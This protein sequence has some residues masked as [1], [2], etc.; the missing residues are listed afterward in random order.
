MDS[1][2]MRRRIPAHLRAHAKRADLPEPDWYAG[3]LAEPVEADTEDAAEEPPTSGS[4]TDGGLENRMQKAERTGKAVARAER[5]GRNLSASV[6]SA[7]GWFVRRKA[8]SGP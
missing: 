2:E 3:P 4:S 5:R 7:Y 6:A 8:P 1:P